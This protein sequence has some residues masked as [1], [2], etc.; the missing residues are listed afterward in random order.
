M[1]EQNAWVAVAVVVIVAIVAGYFGMM[2][3]GNALLAPS[4]TAVAPVC[5]GQRSGGGSTWASG[6]ASGNSDAAVEEAM[7]EAF[8]NCAEEVS[9]EQKEKDNFLSNAQ[10]DCDL[11][12]CNYAPQASDDLDSSKCI[13]DSCNKLTGTEFCQY[14]VVN[15]V[16]ASTGVCRRSAGTSVFVQCFASDGSWSAT[17]S[18]TPKTVSA[19]DATGGE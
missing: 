14:K 19:P 15:G 10:K 11:N 16:I 7:L 6:F 12:N 5:Y 3:G 13:V 8:I 2:A 4:Q 17:A 1:K 18:C 9:E